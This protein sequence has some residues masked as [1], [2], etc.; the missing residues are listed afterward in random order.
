MSRHI[1]GTQRV[2]VERVAGAHVD[3]S[4]GAGTER[5]GAG[6]EGAAVRGKGGRPD[7]GAPAGRKDTRLVTARTDLNQP[8][9]SRRDGVRPG[10]RGPDLGGRWAPVADRPDWVGA[11][12]GGGRDGPG[13]TRGT[14]SGA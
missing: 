3:S 13:G 11:A 5:T 2:G 12:R 8:V 1:L 9:G 4:G 14:R 6:R 7:E 10:G